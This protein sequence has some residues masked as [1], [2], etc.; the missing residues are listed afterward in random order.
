MHICVIVNK[1]SGAASGQD[2]EARRAELIDAF[3]R[4]GVEAFIVVA[5]GDEIQRQARIA[6]QE[7]A[8]GR[9]DAIVI[10]GGDGSVSAVAGVL[11]G[12]DVPLGVL[13][14]G[15][16]N[17]FA[18]DLGLPLDVAGAVDV[19]AAGHVRQV[20]VAKVNDR[21]FVNN[22]SIGLYADMVTD[23]NRQHSDTG[24]GKWAAMLIAAWRVLWRFSMR[25][26][27]IRTEGWLRPCKTPFVFIGN[28]VYDLSLF[29]PGGRAALD[30]GELCLYVLDHRS[31]WGLLWMT[32]RAA[33][34][35]LDQDRDF[36]KR[37]V[38]QV[39]I[40]SVA[41]L[42]RVSVDGE[43]VTMRPPLLYRTRPKALNIFAPATD[44]DEADQSEFI[45]HGISRTFHRSWGG[46]RRRLPVSPGQKAE[47]GRIRP[48]HRRRS[49][50]AGL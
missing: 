17:H 8:K 19:I 49:I 11:A 48:A 32:I 29:N 21:V 10:G 34:G 27:S 37:S 16:L 7:A 45:E 47:T 33:L 5:S 18:K 38:S 50:A 20:D 24:R 43:V 31:P 30:R 4:R 40:H 12:R 1:G 41:P 15:T 22:S 23:R 13:P 42:L 9:F 2:W 14:L 44:R 35:R 28:N 46:T 25:R 6:L 36:Q 39:E 26:L 3:A